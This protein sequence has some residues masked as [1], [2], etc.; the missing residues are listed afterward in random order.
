MAFELKQIVPWG[1]SF[2]EY[3]TMF[4][5]SEEDL[6]KLPAGKSHGQFE[7]RTEASAQARLLRPDSR[8]LSAKGRTSQPHG[9]VEQTSTCRSTRPG[10][11]WP[12]ADKRY[13]LGVTPD[14]F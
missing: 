10:G 13:S 2:T 11:A 5:L 12:A 6:A 1:R 8:K 4:A 9:G 3:V 7:R 14:T